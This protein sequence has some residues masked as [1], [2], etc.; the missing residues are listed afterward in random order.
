MTAVNINL[1]G[2]G[3]RL[4]A[5]FARNASIVQRS[6]FINVRV[7]Y[8]HIYVLTSSRRVR[9]VFLERTRFDGAGAFVLN[10]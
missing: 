3:V 6:T 1:R 8:V 7:R 5:I 9:N 2:G 4:K 10:F